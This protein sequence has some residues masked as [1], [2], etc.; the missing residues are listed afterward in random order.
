MGWTSCR[1]T[2]YNKNGTVN[3]KGEMDERWTQREHD[4]YPELNVLKSRM[5]GSTYYAA[6]EVKRNGVR[7][8]V[9][10]TVALTS[11]DWDD[12]MNF[13]YKDMDETMGPYCYDCPKSILDLLTP[14]DSE[15]ANEWR[16]K[17]R[18]KANAPKLSALPIGTHIKFTRWDGKEIRLFKHSAAYQFKR[19]FWML[20]DGSG[21]LSPKHIADNWVIVE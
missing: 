4:G 10:G 20:E 9:F 11:T 3:R 5:Y 2:H 18:E 19:P 6:I 16:H 12:G 15:Y 13:G 8:K 21:Y 1:A 7:E 17:C 14:T